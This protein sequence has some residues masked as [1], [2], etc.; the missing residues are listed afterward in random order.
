MKYK[1]MY[2]AGT[3]KD[4]RYILITCMRM[5]ESQIYYLWK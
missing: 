5:S 2:T 4:L 3:K 1:V